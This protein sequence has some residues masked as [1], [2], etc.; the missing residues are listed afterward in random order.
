MGSVVGT[1]L[2]FLVKAIGF[3]AEYAWALIVF[4]VGFVAAWLMQRV[5]KG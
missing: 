2:S 4:V 5:K 3:V 1:V